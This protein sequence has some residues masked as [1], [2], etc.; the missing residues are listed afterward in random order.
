MISIC[1]DNSDVAKTHV[2]SL[3]AQRRRDAKCTHG[4]IL[5][6]QGN[7]ATYFDTQRGRWKNYLMTF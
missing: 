5:V 4:E 2:T 1:K 7:L 6:G 3:T